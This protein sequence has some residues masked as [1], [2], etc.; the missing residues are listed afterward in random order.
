MHRQVDQNSDGSSGGDGAQ[1]K[2]QITV[3]RPNESEQERKL[4]SDFNAINCAGHKK[5]QKQNECT[6]T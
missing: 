5:K 6:E 4:L 3:T 1:G 2:E